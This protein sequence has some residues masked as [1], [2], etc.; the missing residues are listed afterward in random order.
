MLMD[1]K[2]NQ[3]LDISHLITKEEIRE[4]I[5][6]LQSLLQSLPFYTDSLYVLP[7]DIEAGIKLRELKSWLL[8]NLT[9]TFGEFREVLQTRCSD[10]L[11]SQYISYLGFK[12]KRTDINGQ[13]TTIYY[14]TNY[15]KFY[16]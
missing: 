3:L 11:L 13:R 6:R 7:S 9:F 14:R 15:E 5:C 8:M 12:S 4:N 2:G 16:I 10:N 1:I